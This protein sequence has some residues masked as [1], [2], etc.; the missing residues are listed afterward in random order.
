[1]INAKHFIQPI[2]EQ[3]K[4]TSFELF[5]SIRKFHRGISKNKRVPVLRE[6][7]GESRV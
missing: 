2:A 6:F 5:L 4:E 7:A 1:M 3:V